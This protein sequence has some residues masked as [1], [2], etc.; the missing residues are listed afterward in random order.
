M[1]CRQV[2]ERALMACQVL[3]EVGQEHDAV[4]VDAYMATCM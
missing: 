3:G 2:E 4:M 1:V